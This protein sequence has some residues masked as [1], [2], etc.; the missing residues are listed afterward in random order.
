MLWPGCGAVWRSRSRLLGTHSILSFI[1][2]SFI[3]FRFRWSIFIDV[4]FFMSF[5][6]KA[7]S[8]TQIHRTVVDVRRRRRC[9]GQHL[10]P[11][12]RS[13]LSDN[14]MNAHTHAHNLFSTNLVEQTN[15]FRWKFR[16]RSCAGQ[17]NQMCLLTWFSFCSNKICPFD[18]LSSVD[19]IQF[20]HWFVSTAI[21][22][23][24]RLRSENRTRPMNIQINRNEQSSINRIRL[25]LKSTVGSQLAKFSFRSHSRWS[26]RIKNTG[27]RQA[28][29]SN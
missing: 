23:V 29:A 19:W 28:V 6:F 18:I 9:P 11:N 17:R 22:S 7:K 2:I 3:P 15:K 10:P 4:I 21:E 20:S 27:S 13:I 26:K 1:I 25:S 12:E 24:L 5:S 8:Y 14:E 16:I